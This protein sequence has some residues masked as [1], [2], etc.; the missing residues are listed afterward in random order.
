MYVLYIKA[1]VRSHIGCAVSVLSNRKDDNLRIEVQMRATK[2]V[3]SVKTYTKIG[4]R[5]SSPNV[6]I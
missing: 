3:S 4:L 1:M 5:N 6:E 2:L